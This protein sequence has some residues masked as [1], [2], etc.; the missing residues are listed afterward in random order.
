MLPKLVLSFNSS[1]EVEHLLPDFSQKSESYGY[2]VP[3]EPAFFESNDD[4]ILAKAHYH[5]PN[6]ELVS[7]KCWFTLNSIKCWGWYTEFTNLTSDH[8]FLVVHVSGYEEDVI[9]ETY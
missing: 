1:A 3:P 2:A 7:G 9:D 4:Y 6:L 8:P 5:S